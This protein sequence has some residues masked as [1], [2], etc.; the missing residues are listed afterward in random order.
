MLKSTVFVGLLLAG[1]ATDVHYRVLPIIVQPHSE[2]PSILV[3]RCATATL[4][5]TSSS[6][7]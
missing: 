1:Y 6:R 4:A 3:Q 7:C 5:T 2:F